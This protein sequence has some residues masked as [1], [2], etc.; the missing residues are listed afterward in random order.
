M[1]E[2]LEKSGVDVKRDR[3]YATSH[4][5]Q[6]NGAFLTSFFKLIDYWNEERL[7][8]S[9]KNRVKGVLIVPKLNEKKQ[10]P[11]VRRIED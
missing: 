6:D 4:L 2:E 1:I 5:L 9:V 10:G 7:P 3:I 11:G 8:P